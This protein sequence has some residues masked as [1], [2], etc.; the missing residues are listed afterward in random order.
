MNK[1]AAIIGL[2]HT[3]TPI[4]T[5]IKQLKVPKFTFYYVVKKYKELGNTKDCPES[6]RLCSCRTTNNNKQF[7]RG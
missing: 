7:G 4:S 2:Y 1:R 6:E 3:G 5:I